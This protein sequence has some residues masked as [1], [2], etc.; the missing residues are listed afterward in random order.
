MKTSSDS[1]LSLKVAEALSK[2]VGRALARMDPADMLSIGAQIGD[3]VEIAGKRRT[4]CKLMPA[5]MESRGRTYLQNTTS[6]IKNCARPEYLE[7]AGPQ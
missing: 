2:D 5:F 6:E 3:I 1:S 7:T 4:V